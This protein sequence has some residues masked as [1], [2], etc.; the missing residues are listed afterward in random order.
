MLP[1]Q[2]DKEEMD[3]KEGLDALFRYASE[4]ILVANSKGEI[5]R[6]NPAAERM[7]GYSA[8]E[9]LGKK[10]EVL[11]PQR[12]A[13]KHVKERAGFNKNPHA[14]RMGIGMNLAGRKK[15]NS[16]FPVEVSLSPFRQDGELFVIAFIIDITVRKGIEDEIKRKKEELE[17][18]AIELRQSNEELQNFAYISSHDLQEPLRKIQSFGDRLR[19]MEAVNMSDKG[20]DYLGR[21]LNAA[22]RMQQL[23]EDLL[24]FSRLTTRA[25]PF[26]LVSLN[27]VLRGV[28]SD[29]EV[30]IEKS[31]ARIIADPLPEIEAEPTQMRQLFQNLI[32]N[33]IKFR[34]EGKAPAIRISASEAESS[35]RKMVEL[36]FKDNGIGFEEKYAVKIFNIFQRL[37]GKKYEGSGIGLS[38]CKKIA[39]M[40]GGSITVKSKPGKGSTFIVTLSARHETPPRNNQHLIS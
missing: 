23:I 27:S 24:T 35:G 33:A 16:E 36:R 15:D 12:A 11:I 8:G 20:R 40:H 5:I 29:L 32:S 21:M 17:Q 37:E 9:L 19:S 38:I 39:S 30:A 2:P 22:E 1:N 31:G 6:I 14:R 3:T 34:Q 28:L 10:V 13:E 7:F 18:L 25:Q 26:T 4:G